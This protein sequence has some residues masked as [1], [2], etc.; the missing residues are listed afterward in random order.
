M[1]F[2]ADD[3]LSRHFK[4]GGADLAKRIDELV[5]LVVSETSPN[6][7]LYREMFVTV[8]RMAQADRNRWDAKIM[9]QTL[10]EMEHAFSRLEQFKRRRKVTANEFCLDIRAHVPDFIKEQRSAVGLFEL[11]FAPCRRAGE[12]ALFM[13][14]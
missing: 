4:T 8:T 12:G 2:E 11:A 14:K 5:A 10:R 3:Y 1:P 7:A 9:L 13:T 6:L